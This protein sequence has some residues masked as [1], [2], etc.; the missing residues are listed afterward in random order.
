METGTRVEDPGHRSKDVDE[1]DTNRSP[2]HRGSEALIPLVTP[3]GRHGVADVS[4]RSRR[5]EIAGKQHREVSL[6]TGFC[7]S[8]PGSVHL[9]D[10]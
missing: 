9:T 7:S 8:I 2:R 1:E 6:L 3:F 4:A 5:R 10:T